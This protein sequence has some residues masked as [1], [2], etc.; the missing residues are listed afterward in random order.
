M[1]LQ[2]RRRRMPRRWLAAAV[3]VL[4]VTMGARKCKLLEPL[5]DAQR[6]RARI[7]IYIGCYIH[8]CSQDQRQ[9]LLRQL[10]A[11]PAAEER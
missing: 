11:M 3:I 10:D 1:E 5:T 6:L 8:A 2:H 7:D 4:L 9:Q